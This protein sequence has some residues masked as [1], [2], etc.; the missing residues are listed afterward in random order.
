MAYTSVTQFPVLTPLPTRNEDAGTTHQPW[1]ARSP[2]HES[3]GDFFRSRSGSVRTGMCHH[4]L[5]CNDVLQRLHPLRRPKTAEIESRPQARHW[6]SH[7]TVAEV[8]RSSAIVENHSQLEVIATSLRQ[9]SESLEV[10]SIHGRASLDFDTDQCT[11]SRFNHKVNLVL[12]FV[13]VVV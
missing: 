8:D 11:S 4:F 10:T 6:R 2:H 1:R 12:I 3:C 13:T 7:K 9:L 5:I